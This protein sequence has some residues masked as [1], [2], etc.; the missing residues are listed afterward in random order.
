M[1]SFR[2]H[3]G[4]GGALGDD[5]GDEAAGDLHLD[6][7]AQHF[8]SCHEIGGSKQGNSL[9]GL[10]RLEDVGDEAAGDLYVLYLHRAA[11]PHLG[12]RA[13]QPDDSLQR[14]HLRVQ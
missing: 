8:E 2:Q 1:R 7:Q 6:S 9:G 4:A 3:S 11:Q 13:G 10:V 14:P 5:V 12:R